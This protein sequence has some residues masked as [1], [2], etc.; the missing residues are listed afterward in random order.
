MV[1]RN[2]SILFLITLSTGA[3]AEAVSKKF[4]TQALLNAFGYK[5]GKVDEI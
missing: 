3:V 1:I 4:E 2:L 5:V